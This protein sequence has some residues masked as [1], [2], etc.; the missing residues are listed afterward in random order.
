[1]VVRP[2]TVRSTSWPATITMALRAEDINDASK[3]GT[4]LSSPL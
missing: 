1:M 4:L 3:T 2:V